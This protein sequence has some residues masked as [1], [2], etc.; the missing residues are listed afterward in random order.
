MLD[1]SVDPDAEWIGRRR[2]V[3]HLPESDVVAP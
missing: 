1:G 2:S 3:D